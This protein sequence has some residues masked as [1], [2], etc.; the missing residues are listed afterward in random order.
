MMWKKQADIL[1]VSDQIVDK[2]MLKTF[3][4]TLFNFHEKLVPKTII[5]ITQHLTNFLLIKEEQS[6]FAFLLFSIM[7]ILFCDNIFQTYL[8]APESAVSQVRE[9]EYCAEI[10]IPRFLENI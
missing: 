5:L 3:I 1:T 7:N 2:V 4:W 10:L 8:F 9:T 6:S